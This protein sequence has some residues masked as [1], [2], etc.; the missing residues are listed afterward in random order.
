MTSVI[1]DVRIS[2]AQR[3]QYRDEG[4]FILE[5][6][7]PTAHL[8]L[9]RDECDRAV[10]EI[11]ADMERQ[12]VEV[13]G[14]NRRGNRYFI[15]QPS[16]H[17][18][19]LRQVLFSDLMAEICR[20]TLGG[21]ALVGWE[22]FVV[23]GAEAGM[24]F[25]WHQDAGYAHSMG[26]VNLPAAVSCW[27]ALDDMSEENGTVYI[28]PYARFGDGKLVEHVRDEEINDLVGYFG[29]DPGIPVIVPAGS[30]AVFSGLAFHRSGFN[31]TNRM[32]RVYLAQYG[33]AVAKH[34]DGSD[35]GRGEPFLENGR[36]VEETLSE[37]VATT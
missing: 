29:D 28:L 35:F 26:A 32:R 27:C 15:A 22:Q 6:M 25:S 34:S 21:T 13:S 9:L 37:G 2:E 33:A 7:L 5:R 1:T 18:P 16:L 19:V 23:K 36:R 14:I 11:D 12:G 10:Q 3:Q 17:R 4:Y 20:A 30:I 24:K 31:T 8:E